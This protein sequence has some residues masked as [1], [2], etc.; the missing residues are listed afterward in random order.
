MDV[1][2]LYPRP[3]HV[4]P[5]AQ[6]V[7]DESCR[8]TWI[9]HSTVSIELDGTR[10]LTDPVLRKRLGFLH[11]VAHLDEQDVPDVDAILI[12]HV[13][14]DH[15][16]LPSLRRFDRSTR[17]V[18]P[19]GAGRYVSRLGFVDV[20]ELRAGEETRVD[21]LTVRATH[22]EH[23]ARRHP[24][25]RTIPSLGYLVTGS[26]SVYFAGDTDLFED[27]HGVAPGVEVALLPIAG[28]GP[29]V[30]A[31]HLDPARAAQAVSRL[32]PRIAIPIHWGTYRRFDLAADTGT[33]REPVEAFTREVAAV[34]PDVTVA[35]LAPGGAI[36]VDPRR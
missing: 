6:P 31:G 28:W 30:P 27:M 23:E 12:S 17:L 21:K 2:A 13:H 3:R 36:E 11:R 29:R 16:D 5:T 26:V 20:V 24:F 33:L 22:A 19:Q 8:L 34:A 14:Y 15:L 9:G 35:V 32:H 25:G 4:G 18:V 10:V 7:A 1:L